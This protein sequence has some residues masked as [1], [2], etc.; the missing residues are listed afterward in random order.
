MFPLRDHNPSGR[1]PY[2]TRLLLVVNIAVF[3]LMWFTLP[4]EAA[5]NRVYFDYGLVPVRFLQGDW[6]GILTSMFLHSGW[7]HLIGNM[8]FLYIFGDNMEDTFGHFGFA[9]FYL[10]SGVAA[11]FLHVAMEAG[12]Y[13]PMVGASGAIAG[14]MGGYLLLFPKARVDIVLFLLIFFRVFSV[15]AWAVLGL[16]F[17]FQLVGLAGVPGLGD[18]VAYWAHVGGFVAGMV[19]AVPL[20]LSLGGPGFWARTDGRPNHPTTDY[21]ASR[22]PLVRRR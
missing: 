6:P 4:D 8:M 16:W 17:L 20:W 1:F 15:P 9:V 13:Q 12:S 2:V 19:L 7:L 10:A 3:L 18:A 22:V 14:A 21:S 11:G 5:R